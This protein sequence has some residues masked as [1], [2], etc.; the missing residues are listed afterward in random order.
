MKLYIWTR[1]QTDGRTDSMRI[2]R[3]LM[4][5]QRRRRRRR[6]ASRTLVQ[7]TKH[8][9][10]QFEAAS[11]CVCLF[12]TVSGCCHFYNSSF[13]FP[14]WLT[15]AGQRSQEKS[16][17]SAEHKSPPTGH[18]PQANFLSSLQPLNERGGVVVGG[19]GWSGDKEPPP[20]RHSR[21]L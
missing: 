19:G 14:G 11:V 21:G 16:R 4:G 6:S 20:H 2:H 12:V 13:P 9:I 17:G 10:K 1:Q 7:L 5:K 15:H 8:Q 18:R 3:L